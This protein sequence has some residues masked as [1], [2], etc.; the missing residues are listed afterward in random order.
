MKLYS[1]LTIVVNFWS[2]GESVNI[3]FEDGET[4]S[5]LN[6]PGLYEP[7]SSCWWS[8][9]IHILFPLP[10]FA[11]S[12]HVRLPYLC[13]IGIYTSTSTNKDLIAIS[14]FWP[15]K[16]LKGKQCLWSSRCHYS[17]Q[18]L[19]RR[20]GKVRNQKNRMLVP[21]SWNAYEKNAFNN[22][23]LMH[24]S[25]HKSAKFLEI[26]DFPELTIISNSQTACLLCY[27]L[28][29]TLTLYLNHTTVSQGYHWIK[30]STFRLW[31]ILRS[32]PLIVFTLEYC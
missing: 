8:Q 27:K 17:P 11:T 22:P 18:W 12:L 16:L 9:S 13:E 32:T 4:F 23:R 1:N 31:L 24:L 14:N 30:H 2:F 25:I 5:K 20:S 26:Y 7:V 28:L 10:S 6:S 29:D 3:F 15:S 19:L 21:D